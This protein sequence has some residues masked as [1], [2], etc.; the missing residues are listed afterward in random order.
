VG[1][2]AGTTGQ[3]LSTP[4]ADRATVKAERRAGVRDADPTTGVGRPV[5]TTECAVGAVAAVEGPATAVIYRAALYAVV[6]TGELLTDDL[7][8]VGDTVGATDDA[9]GASTAVHLQAAAIVD[10][11]AVVWPTRLRDAWG[12]RVDLSV[13]VIAA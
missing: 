5:G 3:D 4:V 11:A 8:L 9:V 6:A 2:C 10:D 7:T 12:V 1:V 13:V